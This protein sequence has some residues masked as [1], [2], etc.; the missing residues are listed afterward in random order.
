MACHIWFDIVL[1][2]KKIKN[3]KWNEELNNLHNMGL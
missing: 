2:P 3:K 1:P